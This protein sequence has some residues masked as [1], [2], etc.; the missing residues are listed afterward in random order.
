M[1]SQRDPLST[2]DPGGS[3]WAC[4]G[5][6]ILAIPAPTRA[7]PTGGATV[8]EGLGERV[9][10]VF[11]E[12]RG[13][14]HLT[15][16]HLET[17]LRQIRL[18]LLEADVALPVV[19]RVHGARQGEGRRRARCCSSSRRL[20]RSPASF[21]TSSSALLGGQNA[22]TRARRAPRR[23][24]ARRSPGLRQDDVR[25]QARA[26]SE[27]ARTLS[28]ARGRRSRAA[29]RRHAAQ[30]RSAR[31]IGV[32]VFDP[33]GRKDP[34]EV[35][36]EGVARGEADRAATRS[37]STRPGGFTSTKSSCG[38]CAR[39]VDAVKPERDPLRRR[40]HDGTGRGALGRGFRGRPAALRASS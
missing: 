35:A 18:S 31:Q 5:S 30:G 24:R 12:L 29:G 23:H 37:S 34:V 27:G 11:K 39:V 40:R 28:A 7:R 17:A 32:P 6:A 9:Q 4:P 16:Y 21:A 10:G 1:I 14:G 19:K 20:R 15:E 2:G 8:F 13:E 26:A 33:A 22:P 3:T 38:R 25:R 36:R